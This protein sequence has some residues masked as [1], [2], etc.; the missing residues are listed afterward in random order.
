MVFFQ[1]MGAMNSD[2]PVLGQ[3]FNTWFPL[4]MVCV[5]G[6]GWVGWGASGVD[7]AARV[8][9][10]AGKD[11][12]SWASVLRLRL[13]HARQAMLAGVDLSCCAPAAPPPP[14]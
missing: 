8:G 14:R 7:G 1:K 6:V 12:A 11:V 13:D 3:E 10:G 9:G 2:V 5:W 4:T